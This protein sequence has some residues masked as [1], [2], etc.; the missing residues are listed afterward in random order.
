MS[1]TTFTKNNLCQYCFNQ[2]NPKDKFCSHCGSKINAPGIPN[3]SKHPAALA[4]GTIL[5]GKYLVG[6]L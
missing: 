3:T 4:E 6:K 2:R 1:T 5:A